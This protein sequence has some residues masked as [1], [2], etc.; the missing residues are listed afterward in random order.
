MKDEDYPEIALFDDEV[1]NI[2]SKIPA[3]DDYWFCDVRLE[4][5]P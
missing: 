2:L 4:R 3:T 5:V 1:F